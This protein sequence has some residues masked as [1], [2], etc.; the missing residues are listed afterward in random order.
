MTTVVFGRFVM[1]ARVV[2]APMA[3]TRRLRSAD[4]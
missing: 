4:S 3:G 1:G 2:L